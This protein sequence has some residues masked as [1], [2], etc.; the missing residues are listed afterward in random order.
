MPWSVHELFELAIA[1]GRWLTVMQSNAINQILLCYTSITIQD[2]DLS[3]SGRQFCQMLQGLVD[4]NP[5]I[6]QIDLVGHSMGGLV[7]RSS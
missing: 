3:H 5:H 7:S 1:R 6:S 4:R 2:V